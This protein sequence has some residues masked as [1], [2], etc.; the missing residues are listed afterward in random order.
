[1][2]DKITFL[3]LIKDRPKFFER[4]VKF[5][6]KD[7]KNI[8]LYI[9]DGGK[10]SLFKKDK[11]KILENKKTIYKKF[12]FDRNYKIFFKKIRS[13]LLD[14]KTK[15]VIFCSDDDLLNLDNIFDTLKILNKKKKLYQGASGKFVKFTG[16]D[17]FN[18]IN[19]PLSGVSFLNQNISFFS[20]NKVM[21]LK[22]FYENPEGALHFII[23]SRIAKKIYNHAILSNLK[24]A[25]MLDL[26]VNSL[27]YTSMNILRVK[28]IFHLHQFHLESDAHSRSYS[29]VKNSRNWKGEKSNYL[30]LLKN[31]LSKN[32]AYISKIELR[33]NFDK[34]F[35]ENIL[36]ENTRKSISF[37][38]VKNILLNKYTNF[39]YVIFKSFFVNKKINSFCDKFSVNKKDKKF[40]ISANHFLSDK[41]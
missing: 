11:I 23:E 39:L 30:N 40:L 38:K 7:F 14:V 9:A 13:S 29:V 24:S 25:D 35:D 4:W 36:Q 12:Q 5:H 41:N 1:M 16:I 6:K 15:Y 2:K 8:N 27:I 18:R 33:H 19:S 22:N 31:F 32:Q 3:L 10:N 26:Y 17:K 21:R 28:K 34:M 37:L 20:N